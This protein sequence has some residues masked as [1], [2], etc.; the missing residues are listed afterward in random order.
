MS[1]SLVENSR[2]LFLTRTPTPG[3]R[4]RIAHFLHFPL[5][6]FA[7]RLGLVKKKS[8]AS[9]TLTPTPPSSFYLLTKRRVQ[10]MGVPPGFKPETCRTTV[11]C[12]SMERHSGVAA[13]AAILFPY[14][15]PFYDVIELSAFSSDPLVGFCWTIYGWLGLI[16]AS[17]LN[18]C[19]PSCTLCG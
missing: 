18:S 1:S 4:Y 2:K 3:Q 13:Q 12:P 7:G 15:T 10:K 8:D 9:I 19:F 14:E 6:D 5:L 11:H 17:N 16:Q